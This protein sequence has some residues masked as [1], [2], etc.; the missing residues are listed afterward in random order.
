MRTV[1]DYQVEMKLFF[2]PFYRLSIM[3]Y[4]CVSRVGR[5][6]VYLNNGHR[7]DPKTYSDKP[8]HLLTDSSFS[9][10][11]GTVWNSEE[12]Y[13]QYKETNNENG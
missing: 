8:P 11:H 6:W 7:F 13:Q 5:R 1:K 12:E 3:K 4:V 9:R 2:V 10:P